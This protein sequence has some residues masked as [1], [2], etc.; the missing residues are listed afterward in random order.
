MTDNI[1]KMY[2]WIE[3]SDDESLSY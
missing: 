2:T 1:R 3:S